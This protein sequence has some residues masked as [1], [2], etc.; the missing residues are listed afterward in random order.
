M[1]SLQTFAVELGGMSKDH[2]KTIN[3]RVEGSNASRLL[4]ITTTAGQLLRSWNCGDSDVGGGSAVH[5][6]C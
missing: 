5:Q 3:V 1:I 4:L 2:E 6:G